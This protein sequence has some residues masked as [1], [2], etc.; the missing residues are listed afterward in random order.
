MLPAFLELAPEISKVDAAFYY[1]YEKG[2]FG[3][4][5][6]DEAVGAISKGSEQSK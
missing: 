4:R 5:S 2:A 1:I 6:G 3:R